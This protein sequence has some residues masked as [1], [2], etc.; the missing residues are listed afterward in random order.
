MDQ[1]LPSHTLLTVAQLPRRDI[2]TYT[3]SSHQ[4]KGRPSSS[5]KADPSGAPAL[6]QSIVC[7]STEQGH[8]HAGPSLGGKRA[9]HHYLQKVSMMLSGAYAPPSRRLALRPI[10][11]SSRKHS[12]LR[13]ICSSCEPEPHRWACGSSS[14]AS[15]TP[16]RCQSRPVM[17]GH[18]PA[19]G[20]A[21]S[22]EP[23][24]GNLGQRGSN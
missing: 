19:V 2:Y 5:R 3:C 13:H 15:G 18:E 12:S 14:C 21:A 23:C 20:S 24:S 16:C 22:Y 11:H 6:S 17:V 7:V 8:S 4:H 10:S 1:G 9:F